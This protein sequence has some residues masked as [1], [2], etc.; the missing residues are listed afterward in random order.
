MPWFKA[1]L[2][3]ACTQRL[4]D[5]RKEEPLQYLHCRAEQWFEAVGANPVSW[6]PCLQNRD[7]EGVLPNCG[8]VNSGNWEVEEL[9]QKGQAVFTKM[10]EVE[11]G[12]PIRALGPWESLPSLWPQR[13]LSRRTACMRVPHGG[14]TSWASENPIL[15]GETG[16]ELLV[17]GLYNHLRAGLGFF[18]KGDWDVWWETRP[19]AA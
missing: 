5:G 1:V 2:G 15:L 14:G 3:G 19:L 9:S 18:I 7:Y 16:S 8:D 17:K 11:H 13:R 12:E 4:S 10:A 6:L